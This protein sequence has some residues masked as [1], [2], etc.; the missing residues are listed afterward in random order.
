M[1]QRIRGVIAPILTPFNHDLS[2]ATELYVAHAHELLDGGCAGLAPFGTTGEALSLSTAERLSLLHALVDSG[3]YPG[4]LLPGAGLNNLAET[5]ALCREFLELGCA[6]LLVLPPFFYK[7]VSDDGLFAY[8]ANLVEAIGHAEP[9]IHLYHI[10][11]V[12][13]VG[14]P[15]PLVERLHRAFPG[16][17]TGIKDSTGDWENT[18]ALLEIDGLSVYPGSELPLIEAMAVGASGCISATANIN[19]GAINRVITLLDAGRQ[20]EAGRLHEI[21]GRIRLAV[22]A[23]GPIP[24]QKRLLATWRKE[25]RWANVRPPLESLPAAT[26]A[27]LAGEIEPLMREARGVDA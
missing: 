8:F 21:N 22:Q 10:P 3:V 16:Q 1:G 26:G 4:R 5:A 12:S 20:E 11:Q 17:I 9:G 18:S 25:G 23:H 19:A 2:V 15:V 24:A 27:A 7:A 14:F 6:G 13:G